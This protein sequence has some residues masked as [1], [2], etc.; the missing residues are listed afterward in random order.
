MTGTA[1]IEPRPPELASPWRTEARAAL[2][3]EARAFARDTVLPLADELDRHKAE[4]P[5]P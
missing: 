5:R 4:M 3:A 1:R 2:Q